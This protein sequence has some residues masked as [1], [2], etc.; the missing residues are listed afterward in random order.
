MWWK[1]KML[2]NVL[3]VFVHVI[4]KVKKIEMFSSLT[5]LIA[6]ESHEHTMLDIFENIVCIHDVSK[7]D[8]FWRNNRD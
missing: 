5:L 6:F 3:Y 2:Y 8:L 1:N 7:N 4:S